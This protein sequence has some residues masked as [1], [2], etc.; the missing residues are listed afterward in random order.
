MN[1]CM[2]VCRYLSR[3]A[4]KALCDVGQCAVHVCDRIVARGQVGARCKRRLEL[5]RKSCFDLLLPHV[6]L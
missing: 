5:L 4:H 1:V 2:Y 3:I 6:T